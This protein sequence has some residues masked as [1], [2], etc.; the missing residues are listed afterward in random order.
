MLRLHVGMINTESTERKAP[1]S[2]MMN[3]DGLGGRFKSGPVVICT[4]RTLP[5]NAI[6]IHILISFHFIFIHLYHHP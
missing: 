4:K 6:I 5:L 3:L 1:F 2:P